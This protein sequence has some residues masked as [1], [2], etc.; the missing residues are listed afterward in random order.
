VAE[1]IITIPAPQGV[2]AALLRRDA[3]WLLV[4][5]QPVPFDS[6]PLRAL[7]AFAEA[8]HSAGPRATVLR[9]PAA[10]LAAP[11]LTRVAAG[12]RLEPDAGN[13]PLRS[14]LPEREAGPPPRLVLRAARPGEAVAVLDP[15]TGGTLL[16]GTVTEGGEATPIGRRAAAAEILPT[17][18]GTAILPRADTIVLR[19]L[20]DRFVVDAG[21]SGLALGADLAPGAAEAAAMSRHFDLPPE[22]VEGL[23]AR[24]RNATLAVAAA[25][26]LG[27]AAPRLRAA[28][29]LLAL[30]LGQ[31]AQAMAALAMRDDPRAANDPRARSLHAAGAL[32][33][34]RLPEA[35]A[36]A[37]E[38]PDTDEAVL[39][40]ALRAAARGESAAAAMLAAK[41][42]LLQAYPEPLRARLLPLAAEALAGGGEGTAARRLLAMRPEN[43]TSLALARARL[44]ES[45][46]DVDGA[47]AAYD[48]IARDRDRRAR[49]IALRRA[50]EL[51][52][53]AARLDAAGAAAALE[54]T[55]AAWRGDTIESDARLR[56][57]ELRMAAG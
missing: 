22:P 54:A 35:E 7:P 45:D 13:A 41:L 5:D 44:L 9:L 16:V 6:A 30:G 50:A 29:A 52:L 55:F 21:L 46:G 27:R 14:I 56:A 57:A 49:A 4:L 8:E 40:R 3:R 18:L 31:E 43:D 10:A 26:P 20:P 28:E 37:A 42:P 15:E 23:W 33:A 1:G 47:L 2:G 48:A 11:R 53:S 51:R 25:P 39:W 34:G 24:E 12:W 17:R 36:L 38:A 32:V 19:A